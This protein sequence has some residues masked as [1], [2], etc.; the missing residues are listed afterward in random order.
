MRTACKKRDLPSSSCLKNFLDQV[1][2]TVF[3]VNKKRTLLI[4]SDTHKNKMQ[5]VKEAM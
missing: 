1:V 2:E 3:P 4:S 5:M